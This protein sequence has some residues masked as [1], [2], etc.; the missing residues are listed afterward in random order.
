MKR[1]SL[2]I[3][4]VEDNP[5]IMKINATALKMRGYEVLCAETLAKSRVLL[6]HHNVAL[7]VLDVMLSDG[8][9]LAFCEELR[10]EQTLPILFLSALGENSDVVAGLRA[11][12]DDY[13]AKPYDLEVLI[14]RIEARLRGLIPAETRLHFG[15]LE[16]DTLSSTAYLDGTDMLLTQKEF[17]LLLLLVRNKNKLLRKDALYQQVWRQPLGNDSRV[18]WTTVS[19]LKKKLQTEKTGIT[20]SSYRTEGYQLEQL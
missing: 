12:G 15:A 16:L 5:H 6:S 18:L 7:I 14:A 19:R 4:L 9:G 10:R 8:N 2:I 11:G 17:S 3:L 1:R 13:L 20:I